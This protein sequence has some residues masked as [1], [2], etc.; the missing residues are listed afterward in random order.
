VFKRA[1]DGRWIGKIQ[2]GWTAN[3]TR[4]VITVS[5]TTEAEAKRRLIEKQRQIAAEGL[6]GVGT[7]R[8][9]VKGW[10]DIWLPSRATVLRPKAYGSC[11]GAVNAH[12]VPA[13]GH[14]RLDELNPGDVRAVHVHVRKAGLSQSTLRNAHWQLMA[15]L[16][17]AT[18][19]GHAVPQRVL[20]VDAPSRGT[21][22]REGI[23]LDQALKLLEVISG[24]PDAA[25][26]VAA[27]LN[28]MR[29]GEC[30]GLTWDCVGD[31][32]LDISWQLQ[33]LP[34]LDPKD[35]G[36]GFRVPDGYEARHL[37]GAYHLVRPKNR[38][39]VVPMVPWLAAAMASWRAVA[40]E[41]PW[42]LVWTDTDSRYGR[43]VQKPYR[44]PED[45][46]RWNELQE[47]A[48]IAHP[49]GRRYTLHE[50]RHTTASLLLEAGID[51]EVAKQIM[52][53]S[54][55][56][57]TRGY[58]TVRTEMMRSALDRVAGRLKLTPSDAQT[59][60]AGATSGGGASD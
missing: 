42:G 19:E 30:L 16:R 23:P 49:S 37:T 20:L 34:Y 46:Q 45:R 15:L 26:W 54:S 60:S 9:T 14:R 52:G 5:A 17:A 10:A 6:P 36:H 58:Q 13:I 40:P 7:S 1:S 53:H 55:I 41:N 47:R 39:H 4:R 38:R 33:P 22:D 8:Q 50:A 48:G 12:I 25:R 3:N 51:P 35:R 2:A 32:A 56:V 24:E 21:S 27:L 43:V 31:D 57:T 18:V 29:Q 28:G 44:A 59:E 11:A